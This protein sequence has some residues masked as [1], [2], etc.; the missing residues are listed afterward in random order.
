MEHIIL[1]NDNLILL[2][3]SLHDPINRLYNNH[4]DH[5]DR[6]SYDNNL[7]PELN[8]LIELR[9]IFTNELLNRCNISGG[10]L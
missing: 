2:I 1:S 9:K 5:K 7:L 3:K 4:L 6:F 10:D 8:R